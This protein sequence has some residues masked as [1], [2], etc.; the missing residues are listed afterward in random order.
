MN[1]KIMFSDEQVEILRDAGYLGE[2]GVFDHVEDGV[3]ELHP[4]VD[5]DEMQRWM[6]KQGVGVAGDCEKCNRI[7]ALEMVM[8][9]PHSTLTE[10]IADA[11]KLMRW[12]EGGD[13]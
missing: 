10:R 11:E 1:Q 3:Y 2:H 8:D 13:S 5:E 12:L 7:F 6:S 9:I 4:P